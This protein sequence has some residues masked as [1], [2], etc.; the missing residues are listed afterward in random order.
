MTTLNNK[1]THKNKT[2]K[3][4][5]TG[6]FNPSELFHKLLTPSGRPQKT[7]INILSD[8]LYQLKPF[9][10]KGSKGGLHF[11]FKGS[12]PHVSYKDFEKKFNI[13]HATTRR[14]FVFLEEVIPIKRQY[15]TKIIDGV[16][17]SNMLHI[18]MCPDFFFEVY[19]VRYEDVIQTPDD[20]EI[21]GISDNSSTPLKLQKNTHNLNFKNTEL[22]T[23][24][25]S[26]RLNGTNKAKTRVNTKIDAKVETSINAEINPKLDAKINNEI[27]AEG[28]SHK[29]TD[30]SL[31]N[32]INIIRYRSTLESKFLKDSSKGFLE[33]KGEEGLGSKQILSSKATST[34]ANIKPSHK[35]TFTPKPKSLSDYLETLTESI[36]IKLRLESGRDFTFFAIKK[37]MLKL[38]NKGFKP[39]FRSIKGFIGYMTKVMINEM[40]ETTT[41]NNETFTPTVN[42]SNEELE[43]REQERFLEKIEAEEGDRSLNGAFKRRLAYDL[44]REVSYAILKTSPKFKLEEGVLTLKTL[45]PIDLNDDIKAK[46]KDIAYQAW[47][48]PVESLR[49]ISTHKKEQN[50]WRENKTKGIFKNIISGAKDYLNPNQAEKDTEPNTSSFRDFSDPSDTN[51]QKDLG[52]SNSSN[53]SSSDSNNQSTNS[54]EKDINSEEEW[55]QSIESE[56]YEVWGEIRL[57]VG[58]YYDW[59]K[60]SH[61]VHKNISCIV[62][63]TTKEIRLTSKTKFAKDWIESNYLIVMERV[64]KEQGYSLNQIVV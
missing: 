20:H 37:I 11:K 53:I 59:F 61:W 43:I 10:R 55:K 64:A 2:N 57:K 1:T 58:R 34:S 7:A 41:L 46:L 12:S 63:E 22:K 38:V 56:Q 17:Y 40:H 4:N 36:A 15:I 14:N 42:I 32:N 47:G 19:G 45:F 28:Y 25:L 44:P 26:L 5:K 23:S 21:I 9:E 13:S 49:I 18:S 29:R 52:R 30:V 51:E 8:I 6:V 33:T 60:E 48:E 50:N 39:L 16:L 24:I 35:K 54:T 31:N 62:D 3:Q 27:N